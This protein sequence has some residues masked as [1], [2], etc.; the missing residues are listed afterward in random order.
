MKAGLQEFESYEE[1]EQPDFEEQLADH[2]IA[3]NG[4]I[5]KIK[6]ELEVLKEK[7]FDISTP[8][9]DDKMAAW[10]TKH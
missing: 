1:F 5:N 10:K 7:T 3:V 6:Q 2:L 8:D 9:P 4:Y